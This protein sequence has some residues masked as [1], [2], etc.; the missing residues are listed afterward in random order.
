MTF[1]SFEFKT[2]AKKENITSN[3]LQNPKFIANFLMNY[4]SSVCNPLSTTKT[5]QQSWS[6]NKTTTI[7]KIMDKEGMV[8]Q[9]KFR[10]DNFPSPITQTHTIIQ[11]WIIQ[12]KQLPVIKLLETPI[13]KV[14]SIL[15]IFNSLIR[16]HWEFHTE[17]SNDFSGI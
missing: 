12:R 13:D 5:N 10:I 15:L 2:S 4:A 9:C 11:I 6:V 1:C 7:I 14:Y 3:A 17:D 8:H 16:Q